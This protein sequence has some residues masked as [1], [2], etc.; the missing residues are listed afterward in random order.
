METTIH[1]FIFWDK[2][3]TKRIAV[4]DYGEVVGVSDPLKDLKTAKKNNT[5]KKT[6]QS[7]PE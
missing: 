2:N 4:T 7:E 3:N 6:R 1:F 5:I